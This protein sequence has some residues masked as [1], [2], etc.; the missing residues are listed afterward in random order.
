VVPTLVLL[1]L[2]LEGG[3]EARQVVA[4]LGHASYTVRESA[5]RKLWHLGPAAR[6]TLEA[7]RLSDNPEVVRRVDAILDKFDWGIFADTPPDVLK[8]IRE[9]RSNN[10]NRQREALTTLLTGG[11]PGIFAASCCLSR[12]YP[13]VQRFELF[14]HV[15]E[16]VRRTVPVLLFED[17]PAAA[18]RLIALNTLS[19]LPD[20]WLDYAAFHHTRGTLAGAIDQ[21]VA[22]AIR[23]PELAACRTAAL[24]VARQ[25]AGQSA[26]AVRTA[27]TLPDDAVGRSFRLSLA[28]ETGRWAD[29]I[30]ATDGKDN[31]PS[32]GLRMFR[33]RKANEPAKV[34]ELVDEMTATA[35]SNPNLTVDWAYALLLYERPLAAIDL[36]TGTPEAHLRADLLAG[37]LVFPNLDAETDTLPDYGQMRFARYVTQ[38]RGPAA[39]RKAFEALNDRLPSGSSYWVRELLRSQMRAGL[40]DLAAATA[41][42]HIARLERSGESTS[43]DTGMTDPFELVFSDDADAARGLWKFLRSRKS[44]V[45]TDPAETMQQVRRLL[46]GREA[47]DAVAAVRTRMPTWLQDTS[48]DRV[49]GR[50]GLAMI[51]QAA[52][53]P[54]TAA[55]ELHRSAEAF[56]Q[57]PLSRAVVTTRAWV[58]DVDESFAIWHDWGLSLLDAGDPGAAA[59]VFESGWRRT[60]DNPLLLYWSGRALLAAGRADEGQRRIALSHQ[61]SLGNAQMRGRFLDELFARGRV[62]ELRTERD[63][64]RACVWVYNKYR[65]N[66]WNQIARASAWLGDFE[67]A[68]EA[69]ER[70]LNHVLKSPDWVFIDTSA[71]LSVPINVRML[72]CRAALAAGRWDDAVP[73]AHAILDIVPGH[74][75][76]AVAVVNA[77]DA[78]R[79]RVDADAVFDRVWKAYQTL[80]TDHPNS[81]WANATAAN[82]AANCRRRLDAATGLARKATLA[83]RENRWYQEV[84]AEVLFRSGDRAGAEKIMTELRRS[85][86]RNAVY[87]RQLDRYR[88]G[89][90]D[91]PQPIG[92]G[93]P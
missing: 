34:E 2:C 39:G 58:F 86:W 85:D 77:L 93:A 73:E 68:A 82:L 89:P 80:L 38:L 78:G 90:L 47:A 25:F 52:G 40:P 81:D 19:P 71:Y 13:P 83:N 55:E 74:T 75:D 48:T 59:Q 53:D 44:E 65:G 7:A 62:S 37:R 63:R 6:P 64:A 70:N 14:K 24:A 28:E 49:T 56:Q 91:S 10:L 88:T 1:L 16:I 9:F 20:S 84:S 35:R 42:R 76:F 61:V 3:A 54:R 15:N 87:R 43:R 30:D 51:A 23:S 8:A 46:T 57:L 12:E 72:R 60:P 29:V 50:R 45:E 69:T 79:R 31:T 41:G 33:L 32:A 92:P 66:V 22:P 21:L 26:A 67:H 11:E 4:D 17:R 5:S 36:L 27:A 18:E